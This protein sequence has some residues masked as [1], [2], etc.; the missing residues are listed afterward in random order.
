MINKY[1]DVLTC[2]ICDGPLNLDPDTTVD[3]YAIYMAITAKNIHQKVDELIGAYL[4][5]TCMACGHHHKYTT[6]DVEK[7]LRKKLTERALLVIIKGFVDESNIIADQ[8]LIYCNKCKGL[9]GKG[10]CPRSI[11]DKCDIKRFPA[12][13]L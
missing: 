6:R 5:Y 11:Y 13:E 10:N 3:E 12:N 2:D 1:I 9:D 8:F 7:R 4:V